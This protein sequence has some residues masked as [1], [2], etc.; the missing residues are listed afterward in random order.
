[1]TTIA[2]VGANGYIG[3]HVVAYMKAQG[4][5][6]ISLSS[7]DGS[8]LEPKTG[9]FPVGLEFEEKL[10]GVIY[11]AQSPHYRNVPEA[12][13][14]LLAVNS[15][16]PVQVAMAAERAG[17]KYFVYLSTG[18]VYRPSFDAMSERHE[19]LGTSW[20]PFSKIQGEQALL[21]LETKLQVS[22]VRVFAVYGP[23]QTD[24]LIPN[25]IESVDTGKP[26]YLAPRTIGIPDG[27]LQINPCHIDDA[28]KFL[29]AIACQG[30]P[31]IMNLAGPQVV[32][33][34]QIV[35]L[36]SAFRG[37]TS[38]ISE[39]SVART[40]NLVA[41]VSLLKAYM[42]GTTFRSIAQGLEQMSRQ[43]TI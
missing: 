5:H 42:M 19:V 26:I 37:I 40:I 38:V 15:V 7:R 31:K 10:D 8:G 39:A 14:H 23:D 28:T 11:A 34:Q 30:G 24:K 3:R 9:L 4:V 18:N 12:A 36:W 1:M 22:V 17:A 35:E 2:V 32:S 27:G 21:F 20:Y 41:D 43:R 29:A 25:L 6:V 33:I 13:W 16:A